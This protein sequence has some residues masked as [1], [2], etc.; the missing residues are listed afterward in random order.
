MK[1]LF[2]YSHSKILS[3]IF[4]FS[5]FITGCT[6]DFLKPD[7]LSFYEPSNTFKT[8]KGLESALATCDKHLR[9]MFFTWDDGDNAPILTEYYFSDLGVS[10]TTDK[11]SAT[12]TAIN[13]NVYLTPTASNSSNTTYWRSF[14]EEAYNGIKY[15]NSIITNINEVPNIE[16]E[17]K[18][19]MLGRAYFHRAIKYYDLVFQFKDVP[20]FTQ[21]VRGPKFDYRSTK[22]SVILNMITKD[23]EFAV[24]KVPENVEY[25]GMITKGACRQLLIKCYLSIGE[26]DKA[27]AQADTLIN[28]SGYQLMTESF[29]D[30]INPMPE[31]HKVVRNVIW[32]LHRPENKMIGENKETILCMI[33]RYGYEGV[34][35]R[36]KMMRNCVPFW[37]AT[38]N[39]GI[40]TPS[41]KQGMDIKKDFIDYRKTYGRG[42]AKIR[43]TNYAQYGM[44]L[45]DTTDLRHDSKSGN[46][47]QMEM[48]KYNHPNLYKNNDPY[49]GK[50]LRLYDEQGKL[51]CTD[52]IRS[53]FSWP[54]YKIWI[55]DRSQ[56]MNTNYDG[57]EGDWYMYR[58]AETYLLRAEA[59]LWKGD[60]VKAAKDVNIIR[61]RAHCTKMFTANDINMGVVMDERARELYMEEWRRVELGRVSYIFAITGQTDEFGQTYTE[62]TIS[63][64][65]Y[66]WQRVK[67]YNNFYNSGIKTRSNVEYT[68]SPYHIFLPVP[69]TAI[70]GNREGIINQNKGYAGYEH[71]IKPFDNLQ[72][73]IASEQDYSND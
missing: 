4:S 54:H 37:P 18:N 43:P 20:L 55:E 38:G 50:H 21:E 31:V 56:E 19:E 71:N 62:E 22:R 65:S 15:A 14:W 67:K 63:D 46:W 12:A 2:T 70:D 26:F 60:K 49:A 40:M 51:L 30:F 9:N 3:I 29:G 59:Y 66:W 57:G 10:G 34:S 41:G 48:L 8:R 47:M 52:T 36:T 45:G 28:L 6:D 23:L 27:I 39:I 64:N 25:G 58:L 1:E 61:K 11:S 35:V 7:P 42:V 72:D 5:F 68:I 33:N 13:M 24:Q 69:Q 44:W 73:A 53:W 32:D 17:L 16:P